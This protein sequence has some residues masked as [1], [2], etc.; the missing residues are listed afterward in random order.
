[1]FS[2]K[3]IESSEKVKVARLLAKRLADVI[4]KDLIVFHKHLSS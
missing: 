1:M 2:D 3:T 4:I